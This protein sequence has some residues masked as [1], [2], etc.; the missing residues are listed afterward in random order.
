[1]S[2]SELYCESCDYA[3]PINDDILGNLQAGLTKRELFAA[4]AMQGILTKCKSDWS[5][6]PCTGA[7]AKRAVYE[8]DTLI[9]E[10]NK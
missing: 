4:M 10:L 2:E 7:V 8:A 6:G 1:M 5:A 3:Y 9:K